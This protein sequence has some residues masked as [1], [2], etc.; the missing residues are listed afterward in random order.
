[1]ICFGLMPNQFLCGFYRK[2]VSFLKGPDE[3]S[4]PFPNIGHFIVQQSAEKTFQQKFF[5]QPDQGGHGLQSYHLGHVGGPTRWRTKIS[6]GSII[7]AGNAFLAC[8][9]FDV[10]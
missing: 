1:M 10:R 7:Y 6:S 9:K 5:Q 2:S 8:M 4:I 3:L